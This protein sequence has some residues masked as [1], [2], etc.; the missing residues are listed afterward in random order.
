MTVSATTTH[1]VE[2]GLLGSARYPYRAVCSCGWESPTYVA[3]HAAQGMA[4]DHLNP[5]PYVPITFG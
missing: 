5:R 2:V 4:D 1:N 3:A